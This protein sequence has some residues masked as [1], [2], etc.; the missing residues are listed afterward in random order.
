MKAHNANRFP[1]MNK[2]E[3]KEL[4]IDIKKNGL[5]EPIIL[6]EDKI[7][8]GRNRYNACKELDVKIK[9]IE[10]KG[11]N[12][13]QYVISTNLKRRHLNESQRAMV[14]TNHRKAFDDEAK[15]RQDNPFSGSKF[16]IG[17]EGVVEQ[18][19]QGTARD[20]L[21]EAFSVSGRMIDMAEVIKKKAPKKVKAIVKGEEKLSSVYREIKIKEQEK[22]IG[23][24]KPEKELSGV[25]DIIVMDPP[26]NYG[27]EYDPD[28]SRIASPYP[29]MNQKQLLN[30]NIPVD[31][32]GIMF[33]WTTHQFIWEA[34]ELLE[35]WGYD[36]KAILV[37][38]KEKMGLGSWL[39]MQCEFCL[40]GI[41]GKPH[42]NIKDMR[43]LIRAPRKKHS[44]KPEE[45][46][47]LIDKYF[48]KKFRKLDYF[49]RKKREGWIVYG[50]EVKST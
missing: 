16:S 40:L 22:E 11:K 24:L 35:S 41:K 26:W 45:F 37:W 44:Q 43:D 42:W 6:F 48:D 39:R 50:D 33:L 29:E 38:D 47:N 3:Y 34:K 25:Y 36:Y 13:L 32:D 21:G 20:K 31:K 4:K 12:P 18:V 30:M 19:P 9:T 27:R 10:Y 14:A 49:A 17:N 8:D 5:L 23:K 46:Y 7:L 28:S 1:L 2:K 15:K